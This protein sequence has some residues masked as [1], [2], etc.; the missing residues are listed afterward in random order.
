MKLNDCDCR[1]CG[2]VETRR[3]LMHLIDL[4]DAMQVSDV[5]LALCVGAMIDLSEYAL[6]VAVAT[7]ARLNALLPPRTVGEAVHQG[8]MLDALE[9]WARHRRHHR[10]CVVGTV[11]GCGQKVPGGAV[12]VWEGGFCFKEQAPAPTTPKTPKPSR[13]R[14]GR[15][16]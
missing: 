9:G 13:T 12:G 6:R 4:L 11:C 15:A 10:S 8:R 16:K 3:G 2:Q 1:I 7:H 14:D 5:N